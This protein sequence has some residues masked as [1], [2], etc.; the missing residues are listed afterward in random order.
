MIGRLL[1]IRIL[2]RIIF[3]NVSERSVTF[4]VRGKEK[5]RTQEVI[6]GLRFDSRAGI[7]VTIGNTKQIGS[8]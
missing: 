5:K 8:V 7:P 6:R 4:E 1:C 2:S 3:D